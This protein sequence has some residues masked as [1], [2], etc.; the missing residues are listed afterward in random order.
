LEYNIKLLRACDGQ[1]VD[2]VLSTLTNK[3]LDDF[4]VFWKPR[5]QQSTEGDGHWDWSKKHQR[6]ASSLNYEKYA[7]ECEKITQGLMMLE[8]DFHRSQMEPGKNL[9][10][11]DFLAAA[12]WNRPSRQDRQFKAVG[13]HLLRLARQRSLDLGYGGRVGLHSLPSAENFYSSHGMADFGCDSDKEKLTY[14]EW[15]RLN[16]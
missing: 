8:I 11:V 9:V 16:K 3:H 7:I 1:A 2:A 5:L 14:F 4:E 15:G 10:Y 12:P 6:T 13:T